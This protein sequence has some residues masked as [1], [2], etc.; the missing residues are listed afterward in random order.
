MG[1]SYKMNARNERWRKQKQRKQDKRAR[2]FPSIPPI[3][4]EDGFERAPFD[5]PPW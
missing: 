5:D 1:K 4:N 2:R 3:K